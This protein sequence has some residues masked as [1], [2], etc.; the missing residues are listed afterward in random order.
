MPIA[1]FW[2]SD[3]YFQQALVSELA[4]IAPHAKLIILIT[5]FGQF[6]YV[7]DTKSPS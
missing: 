4:E 3:S 5:G 1:G 7:N 2:V 6:L